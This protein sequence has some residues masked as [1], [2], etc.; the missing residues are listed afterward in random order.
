MIK[1][2][3]QAM[4]LAAVVMSGL[5]GSASAQVNTL[6]T[7]IKVDFDFNVG[8]RQLPAGEYRIKFLNNDNSQKLL[9]ISSADG[10]THAIINGMTAPNTTRTEP[11]AVTFTQYGDKY[12]ISRINIGDPAFT[13]EVI[14]SRAERDAARIVANVSTTRVIVPGNE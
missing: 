8:N 5:V 6:A 3:M 10:K 1:K 12:F 13:Q 2:F 4:F 9:M 7:K 14:K 11:G